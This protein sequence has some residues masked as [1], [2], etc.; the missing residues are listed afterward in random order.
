[1]TQFEY[2]KNRKKFATNFDLY[3]CVMIDLAFGGCTGCCS[4]K[5]H[6]HTTQTIEHRGSIWPGVQC[7]FSLFGV[8]GDPILDRYLT[9]TVRYEPVPPECALFKGQVIATNVY[10]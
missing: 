1:M 2:I 3:G 4:L 10:R 7:I 5:S 8:D 6:P 9:T